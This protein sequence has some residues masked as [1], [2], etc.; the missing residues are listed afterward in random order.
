MKKLEPNGILKMKKH[1]EDCFHLGVKAV[2][3]N[4][5]KKILLLERHHPYRGVYWD[6]PGGRLQ[7][8]ES[9]LEALSREVREETG[10]DDIRGA[11]PFMMTLTN[12]RIPHQES[13]VGLIFS[14]FILTLS[15]S[16]HPILSNEHINFEWCDYLNATEKLKLQYPS[17]L[18]ENLIALKSTL[19]V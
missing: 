17:E 4:Q 1:Q 11:H 13:D 9:Q 8:G 14:I 5:D 15:N 19:I 10:W 2:L 6:L 3:I 12:I 7:R 18:I 16:F